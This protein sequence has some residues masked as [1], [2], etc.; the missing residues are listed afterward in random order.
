VRLALRSST[1]NFTT[2]V[3][4][5]VSDLR[6]W[7]IEGEAA[8]ALKTAGPG[9]REIAAVGGGEGRADADK[10]IWLAVV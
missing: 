9:H 4:A 2:S 3:F 1:P 10:F 5:C 6:S 7:R 8:E